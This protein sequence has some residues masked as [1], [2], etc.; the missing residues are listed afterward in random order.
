MGQN[1]TL[2]KHS[3][4]DQELVVSN[5]VFGDE[6]GGSSFQPYAVRYGNPLPDGGSCGGCWEYKTHDGTYY[7]ISASKN[8]ASSH[9]YCTRDG[10][11]WTIANDGTTNLIFDDTFTPE[12]W[13][14]FDKFWV[15]D[16]NSDVWTFNGTDW[17]KAGTCKA[18]WSDDAGAVVAGEHKYAISITVNS[19]E[20][21]LG[22]A[23]NAPSVSGAKG[24]IELTHILL[25]PLAGT[26]KRTVYK[27][28]ADENTFYKLVD[29]LDNSTTTYV[30]S[31]DDSALSSIMPSTADSSTVIAPVPKAYYPVSHDHRM[32]LLKDPDDPTLI[33]YSEFDCPHLFKPTNYE[34]LP[35]ESEVIWG[36]AS[37]YGELIVATENN[38]WI[39]MGDNVNSRFKLE[40]RVEG[41]GCLFHRTMKPYFRGEQQLIVFL[42]RDGW[43][44]YDGSKNPPLLS[45]QIKKMFHNVLQPQQIVGN[46]S[47]STQGDWA[48]GTISQS[49]TPASDDL[50]LT[51]KTGS[52]VLARAAQVVGYPPVSGCYYQ[53]EGFAGVNTSDAVFVSPASGGWDNPLNYLKSL[54]AIGGGVQ[55]RIVMPTIGFRAD[56]ASFNFRMRLNG[57]SSWSCRHFFVYITYDNGDGTTSIQW[58]HYLPDSFSATIF[59]YSLDW[60]QHTITVA[61]DPNKK[62]IEMCINVAFENSGNVPPAGSGPNMEFYCGGSAYSYTPYKTYG[63]WKSD[64]IDTTITGMKTWNNLN[65]LDVPNG[66]YINYY[67]RGA[68]DT[69]DPDDDTTPTWILTNTNSDDSDPITLPVTNKFVQLAA[70]LQQ[71]GVTISDPTPSD[72]GEYYSASSGL[73]PDNTGTGVPFT[74]LSGTTQFVIVNGDEKSLW[75]GQNT[76]DQALL[77]RG[78]TADTT[79]VDTTGWSVS[80]KFKTDGSTQGKTCFYVEDDAIGIGVTFDTATNKIYL[81]DIAGDFSIISAEGDLSVTGDF[82]AGIADG[83]WHVIKLC[84]KNSSAKVYFD[85]RVSPIIEG[86]CN[87]PTMSNPQGLYVGR[88]F[89]TVGDSTP[90]SNYIYWIKW[91]NSGPGYPVVSGVEDN[92]SPELVSM[93]LSWKSANDGIDPTTSASSVFFGDRYL[94]AVTEDGEFS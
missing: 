58:V 16:G 92:N 45:R 72:A 2:A 15:T 75:L 33:W 31:A 6:I 79:F 61:T 69:F 90:F 34:R 56:T 42:S 47:Y 91:D 41:I 81:F 30:D 35:I 55:Y 23:S 80:M 87:M 32:F 39:L 64:I 82:G 14:F 25:G 48:A 37:F 85:D 67:I 44:G 27:T 54:V 74:V 89:D 86:V 49:G 19:V 1:D 76:D 73:Y 24:S 8:G 29:I 9:L 93:Y 4:K 36:G 66:H 11:T 10:K 7:L 77:Y 57:V 88:R 84:V 3:I 59:P 5:N 68:D 83:D 26:T 43:R 38:L 60:A 63:K 51:T 21:I 70:E 17:I 62:I 13:V 22:V 94:C 18:A 52:V 46:K 65:I 40:R 28:K 12:G 50:S 78:L 71:T 53:V 20:Y